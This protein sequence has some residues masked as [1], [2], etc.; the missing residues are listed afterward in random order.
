MSNSSDAAVVS[1]RLTSL[2]ESTVADPAAIRLVLSALIAAR[3]TSWELLVA[4]P[5]KDM[6]VKIRAPEQ[7]LGLAVPL[8]VA[9]NAAL[10]TGQHATALL[11]TEVCVMT[12]RLASIVL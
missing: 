11:F 12:V 2:L 7:E 10:R 6:A 1:Q 3:R 8:Q 5:D 9:V 4:R